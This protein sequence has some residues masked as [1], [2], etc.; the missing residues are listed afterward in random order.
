MR[1]YP[2]CQHQDGR[3]IKR[4]EVQRDY[5]NPDYF[6]VSRIKESVN[7][8]K[9]RVHCFF[10][11]KARGTYVNAIYSITVKDSQDG[12]KGLFPDETSPTISIWKPL[13]C[14]LIALSYSFLFKLAVTVLGLSF[15]SR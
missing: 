9:R 8:F 14:A 4:Q 3:L 11:N 12:I 5:S 10:L 7:P 1:K 6:K 13:S 15:S 2:S